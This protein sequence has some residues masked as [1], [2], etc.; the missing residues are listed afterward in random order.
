[1]TS[2]KWALL[3]VLCFVLLIGD[4][5]LGCYLDIKWRFACLV[6]GILFFAAGAFCGIQAERKDGDRR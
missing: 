1:M 6:Q 3:A 2:L 4:T 5:W